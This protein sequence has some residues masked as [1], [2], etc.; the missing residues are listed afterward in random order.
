MLKNEVQAHWQAE[1]CG[2]RQLPTEDRRAFFARLERQRYAAEPCIREF[3]RFDEAKGL[4]V[5]EIGVGAG[6]DFL[7]WVRA[8]AE[9]TGVDLTAAGVALTR[10]RLALEGLE[11]QVR[12]ADAETLPFADDS[13]DLV[14]SWGVLHH[15]PDTAG[16]LREAVRVLR[17]AGRAR[18][19]LYQHPS[20]SG[21]ILWGST[22]RHA[23]SR[24]R[25][26]VKWCTNTWRV[27]GRRVIP[28]PRRETWPARPVSSMSVCVQ[29]YWRGTCS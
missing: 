17:P 1:P 24:G 15:T 21:L 22:R 2:T 28:A 8:G 23:G 19:M 20:L 6:T 3:A 11:A 18:V 10:E 9:A 13:F 5:L 7:Q 16:A 14:Y 29:S 12:E 25:V 26:L 4:R 27:R